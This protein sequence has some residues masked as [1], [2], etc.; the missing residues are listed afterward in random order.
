MA[1]YT[2]FVVSTGSVKFLRCPS[3]NNMIF[4]CPVANFCLYIFS[5]A[6]CVSPKLLQLGYLGGPQAAAPPPRL[7]I[8][9]SKPVAGI[10][11]IARMMKT[12]H[13]LQDLGQA[14]A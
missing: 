4:A 2:I 5:T 11:A 8:S 9:S 10:P 3:A 1:N 13:S 7:P 12:G 14:R 6:E